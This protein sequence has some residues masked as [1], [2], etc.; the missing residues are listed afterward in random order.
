[1]LGTCVNDLSRVAAQQCGGWELTDVEAGSG[2][3]DLLIA[4]AALSTEPHN[5]IIFEISR[6]PQ[7]SAAPLSSAILGK[8][9]THTCLCHQAV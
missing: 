1:M 9:L 4:A 8:L 5:Y 3:S 6:T 7:I 2:T